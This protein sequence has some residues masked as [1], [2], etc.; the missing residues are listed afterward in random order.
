MTRFSEEN[1]IRKKPKSS[2]S[3]D[4]RLVHASYFHAMNLFDLKILKLISF[5]T[6]FFQSKKFV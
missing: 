2:Q 3:H 5:N 1:G 4:C 6:K